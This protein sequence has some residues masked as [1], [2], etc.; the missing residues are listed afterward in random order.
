MATHGPQKKKVFEE[1]VIVD[2]LISKN[3][4]LANMPADLRIPIQLT[5]LTFC[6]HRSR[7]NRVQSSN[8][9]ISLT[10]NVALVM[11]E[12]LILIS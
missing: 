9:T 6:S 1:Q 2:R 7:V 5:T 3:M 8:L 10:G 4:Q 12:L 11:V